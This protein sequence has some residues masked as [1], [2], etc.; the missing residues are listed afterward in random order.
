MVDSIV[1][2]HIEDSSKHPVTSAG[3]KTFNSAGACI[4][5]CTDD[6]PLDSSYRSAWEAW[7]KEEASKH[8]AE[9]AVGDTGGS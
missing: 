4:V 1:F 9:A 3:Y 8:G 5:Y 7:K 2:F 6:G